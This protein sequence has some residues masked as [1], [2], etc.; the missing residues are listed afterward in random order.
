MYAPKVSFMLLVSWLTGEY[1]LAV[2]SLR[3]TKSKQIQAGSIVRDKGGRKI[4]L[5]LSYPG[6]YGGGGLFQEI[7]EEPLVGRALA[8]AEL[9]DVG[10]LERLRLL[11]HLLVHVLLPLVVLLGRRAGDDSHAVKPKSILRGDSSVYAHG[12]G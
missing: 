11:P 12:L 8:V 5:L 6:C 1:E 3:L 9:V 4:N 7:P 2:I 10:R